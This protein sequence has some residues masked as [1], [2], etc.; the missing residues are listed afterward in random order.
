M[1]ESHYLKILP[2]LVLKLDIAGNSCRLIRKVPCPVYQQ[3]RGYEIRR[4]TIAREKL[5]LLNDSLEVLQIIQFIFKMKKETY[6]LLHWYHFV[7]S[8]EV[9]QL[10]ESRLIKLMF[11]CVTVLSLRLFRTNCVIRRVQMRGD[12][13]WIN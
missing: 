7:N 4:S 11:L 2:V 10:W 12:F 13:K 6:H 3:A 5:Y 1:T 8:V 9:H